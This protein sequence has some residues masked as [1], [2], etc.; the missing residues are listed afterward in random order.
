[1]PK[2]H[3]NSFTLIPHTQHLPRVRAE[4]VINNLKGGFQLISLIHSIQLLKILLQIIIV[5]V[6]ANEDDD[7]DTATGKDGKHFWPIHTP[8]PST[9]RKIKGQRDKHVNE[10]LCI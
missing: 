2:I 1:M 10:V 7:D 5:N 4:N 6:F 8:S 3:I 9:T